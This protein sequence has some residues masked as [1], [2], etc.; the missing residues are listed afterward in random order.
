MARRG[1]MNGR[2]GWYFRV[3]ES[4]M[5]AANDTGR[6]EVRPHPA[7]TIERV[8]HLLY[9]DCLNKAA[10]TE[11]AALPGLP[12]SWRNLAV[13]RLSTG[14]VESWSRRIETPA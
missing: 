2:T 1:Q 8:S 7:W 4:G 9:H 6:L 14:Q 11:F 5:I 13:S 10:L 3:L 12:E